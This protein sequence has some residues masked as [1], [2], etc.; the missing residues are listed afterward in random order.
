MAASKSSHKESIGSVV[1]ALVR[2]AFWEIKEAVLVSG[3]EVFV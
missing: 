1:A 3:A 2:M